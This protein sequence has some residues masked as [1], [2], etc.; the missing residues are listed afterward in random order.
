MVPSFI[1]MDRY[2]FLSIFAVEPGGLH[3]VAV[4]LWTIK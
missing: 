3:A 4:K 1:Q 2:G